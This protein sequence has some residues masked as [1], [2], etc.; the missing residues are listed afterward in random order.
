[1][2]NELKAFMVKAREP[3]HI[4]CSCECLVSYHLAMEQ[5]TLVSSCELSFKKR[6]FR[7]LVTLL[8]NTIQFIFS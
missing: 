8:S 7:N 5:Q 3:V 6:R 1:M 4:D 2:E